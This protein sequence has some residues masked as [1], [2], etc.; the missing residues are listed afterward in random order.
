MVDLLNLL[1]MLTLNTLQAVYLIFVH[2]V[3]HFFQSC[4]QEYPNEGL[5]PDLCDKYVTNINK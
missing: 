4:Y 1:K 3:F 2:Y 5:Y